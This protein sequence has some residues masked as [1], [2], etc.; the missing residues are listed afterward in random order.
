MAIDIPIRCECGQLRAV[1]HDVT[2]ARSNRVMCYCDDCQAFAHFLGRQDQVLDPQGGSDIVQMS[3]A[4]I[5]WTQGREQ[6]ACVRLSD[7]GVARWYAGCCRSPIGN[8]SASPAMPFVGLLGSALAKN[9]A[10][11]AADEALGTVRGTLW[12][13]FA[14][15]V[16]GESAPS[17]RG[18]AVVVLRFARILIGARLRGEH[19]RSAFFDPVTSEPIVEP[20]ILT[21]DERAKVMESVASAGS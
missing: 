19:K 2:P 5:E 10:G 14:K 3:A 4:N 1:A 15:D 16:P 17:N 11:P 8:T 21:R 12:A 9:G 7:K 20:Q 6:L 18:L 13:K